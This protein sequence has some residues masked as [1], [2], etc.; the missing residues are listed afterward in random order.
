MSEEEYSKISFSAPS[1]WGTITGVWL[2]LPAGK[3]VYHKI[4]PESRDL[5]TTVEE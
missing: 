1:D 3:G 2:P 4:G 5:K